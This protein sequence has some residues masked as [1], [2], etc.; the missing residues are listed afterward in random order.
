MNHD[1]QAPQGYALT[2]EFRIPAVGEAYMHPNV[3]RKL[4]ATYYCIPRRNGESRYI[5][6]VEP[7]ALD[8]RELAVTV[9]T[10]KTITILGQDFTESAARI[11]RN[12]ITEA[13]A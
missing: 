2:G 10:T 1:P 4:T 11:L 9:K 8:D 5:L 6:R 7:V 3:N 13:L 12:D